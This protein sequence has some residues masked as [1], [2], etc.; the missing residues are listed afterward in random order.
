MIS[1]TPQL[2]VADPNQKVLS[3]ADILSTDISSQLSRNSQRRIGNVK[4]VV[5]IVAVL[6]IEC[7]NQM[8]A[9]LSSFL[10]RT[11][12]NLKLS[13][14]TRQTQQYLNPSNWIVGLRYSDSWLKFI[15]IIIFFFI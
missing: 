10:I 6:L 14:L 8:K 7:G 9:L 4:G 12:S 15:I 13:K 3:M 1:T 5:L 2:L 11:F